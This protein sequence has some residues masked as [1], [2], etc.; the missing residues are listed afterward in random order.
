MIKDIRDL[1]I[2][3]GKVVGINFNQK[4]GNMT[5]AWSAD[6]KT[7]EFLL[8]LGPAN[9]RVILG[10]NMLSNVTNPTELVPPNGNNYK[11]QV[12]WRDAATGK[13][14]AASDYFSPAPV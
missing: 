7:Q 3:P 4:T 14:L 6:Q 11:E 1:D 9:H 13:L 8:L 5:L 12:Q 2:G 10:T